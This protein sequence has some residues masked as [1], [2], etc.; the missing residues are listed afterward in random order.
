VSPPPIDLSDAVFENGID[1][2]FRSDSEILAL[3]PGERILIVKNA[4]A[5]EF[6]YGTG[7]PVAGV[8]QNGTDLSNGGENITLSNDTT[9][10]T[11]QDFAYSDTSPWTEAADGHGYSLT[12]ACPAA[13]AH[14]TDPLNWR[15]SREVGGT[16]GGEDRIS[17]ADWLS[18]HGL[19]A[20]QE[21]SDLDRDGLSALLEYAVGGDPNDSSDGNVFLPAVASLEVDEQTDN[22]LVLQFPRLKGADDVRVTAEVSAD[23]ITWSDAGPVVDYQFSSGNLVEVLMVRAPIPAGSEAQFIRLRVESR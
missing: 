12:L 19:A 10:E 18:T 15:A 5:F 4:A 2:N 3:D 1:F 23:L 9:G 14:L 17:L 7:L 22:Y 20:G 6:R 16:P 21:E 11:I 13:G 8:F